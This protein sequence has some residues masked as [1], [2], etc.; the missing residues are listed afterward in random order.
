MYIVL[1]TVVTHLGALDEFLLTL[2]HILRLTTPR[3]EHRRLQGASVAEAQ[4]PWLAS[5][6]VIDGVQMN[7][8]LLL[9]L[10]SGQEGD[11]CITQ[12]IISL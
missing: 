2:A 10:T 3:R 9:R 1:E 7:R 4:R 5:L 12:I 6:G 8:R 11:S